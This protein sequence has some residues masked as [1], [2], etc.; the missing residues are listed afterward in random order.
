MKN[1]SCV[2]CHSPRAGW[3][4]K[5]SPSAVQR[6]LP[7]SL[8][9]TRQ[10][11]APG[12]GIALSLTVTGGLILAH[13]L[14]TLPFVIVTILSGL[15]HVD[16]TLERAA[17]I[18][19]ASRIVAFVKIT[20]PLIRPSIIAAALFGFLI[21]FDELVIAY[22]LTSTSTQ[23]LPVKMYSAIRWE[24]SPVLAA[25]ATLLTAFSFVVCIGTA[26]LQREQKADV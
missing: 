9:V 15:R 23:T 4:F 14:I 3:R 13:A 12:F 16:P 17:H 5:G 19:G 2:R 20:L 11:F 8:S 7:C 1:S 6:R 18:M 10:A 26:L 22:F 24:I 25:V 21:S